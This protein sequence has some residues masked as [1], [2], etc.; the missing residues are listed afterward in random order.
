M[1]YEVDISCI[2]NKSTTVTVDAPDKETIYKYD[3]ESGW[4]WS[5]AD[6]A[7]LTTEIEGIT[8]MDRDMDD[9]PDVDLMPPVDEY[10]PMDDLQV[11]LAYLNTCDTTKIKDRVKRLQKWITEQLEASGCPEPPDDADLEYANGL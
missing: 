4:D 1:R 9:E 6:E 11:V 8:E 10:V 3:W 5:G 7:D 2:I